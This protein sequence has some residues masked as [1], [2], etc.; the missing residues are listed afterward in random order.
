ML[1]G[2]QM[3]KDAEPSSFLLVRKEFVMEYILRLNFKASN[4]E[5]E[6]EVLIVGLGIAKKLEVKDIK[7]FTNS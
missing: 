1:M 6:Y 4:D 2:L 5:V 7:V 3:H